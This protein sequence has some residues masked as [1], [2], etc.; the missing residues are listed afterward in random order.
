MISKKLNFI[1]I[2][3]QKSGTTSLRM[4]L[5][6]HPK[7]NLPYGSKEAPF[8]NIDSEYKKGWDQ[9]L[10]SN[11]TNFSKYDFLGKVS[12][13]Y[14]CD[15]RVPERIHETLPEVKLIALLR[16]PIDRAFSHYKMSVRRD[17]EKRNFDR[18]VKESLNPE[19]LAYS[20][21]LVISNKESETSCY[22]VWGEYGR[23]LSNYLEF[24]GKDRVLVVFSE[25]LES[26]PLSVVNR[27]IDFIGLKQDFIP[28]NIYDR[29]HV[30]AKD[31]ALKNLKRNIFLSSTWKFI[32]ESFRPSTRAFL[33]YL[34]DLAYLMPSRSNKINK[35][36]R[37]NLNNFYKNDVQH[38]TQSF[39]IV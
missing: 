14:M 29:F 39:N 36:T 23:I 3:A 26:Q 6:E 18:I 21:S 1:V 8:F 13:Q 10:N 28:N 34:V 22:F 30:G 15:F 7:I 4:Y 11:F 31:S 20:R 24:F 32:P 27:I 33:K 9:Y 35:N 25:H 17:L 19:V 2:G 5:Q 38:L 16:N 12:P 37:R